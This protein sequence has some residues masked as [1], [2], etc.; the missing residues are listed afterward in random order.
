MKISVIIPVYNEKS[1]ISEIIARVRAVDLEKEIIV[2]DDGS[3]DGTPQQLA[4]IDGQFEDVKVLSHQEN[5]GKGAALRTGFAAASG[6]ILIVQDADLEYDPRE[7]EALLV[8]ILDGRAEIVYG[9]RFLSGPHRVL[10]FWHYVGNKFLTLLCDA[11]SNLN[12]TDMETCYKVFKKEVLD[13][14]QLKSNRF[15]FEPEFTM[16]I[17]KKGFRVYEVPISYSG[18]TYEEGKKIGW[19]D[20]LAAIFTIIWFRFFD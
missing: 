3:T 6:E 12:L 9:S 14:I 2:I 7:Y 13:D 5:R 15:G 18:R 16:K 17:A 10:F 19:R 20:G 1:T 8:P 11:L 4:E